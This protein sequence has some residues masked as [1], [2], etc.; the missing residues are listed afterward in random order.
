MKTRTGLSR[1]LACVSGMM[2]H[3]IEDKAMRATLTFPIIACG[4]GVHL[5]AHAGEAAKTMFQRPLRIVVP[6]AP[7]GGQDTTAR[8]LGAKMTEFIGQQVLVDNRPGG[9]GII[10]AETT[11]K[12]P[13][14]GHTLYLASTSFVVTPSL[15]K[16][17]PFDTVKDFA[18]IMRVSN[19][20]GV[21]AVHASLPANSVRELVQLAKS[22]PGQ[23][24]FGSSGVAGNS[25]LSGELFKLLAGVDII[26]VPYKGSAPAMAALVAGEIIIGFSN[27]VTTIPHVRAGRLKALG[28]TT[29][30]RSALLPD[31][32]SIADAG[33]PGFENTIWSG[34]VVNASTPRPMQ[35]ALH[36][37]VT[38]S[39]ESA[40]VKE[41][42]AR[43]GAEPFLGDTPS[44]Y[45]AFIAAE[46]EKWRKVVQRAGVQVQ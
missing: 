28:V 40:E 26:H 46:I 33:V 15:R 23:I 25:H 18:P 36:E 21:L 3:R 29:L 13:P 45:G 19:S 1:S 8:L 9:A 17:M 43:D 42:L 24:T 10:A 7:G 37:F 4:I 2:P 22:K 38:R 11:L 31:I 27:A 30:K 35:A 44:S 20:P 32:P 6:F 16:S 14:D 5:A 39:I 12:A 34:V 41:R